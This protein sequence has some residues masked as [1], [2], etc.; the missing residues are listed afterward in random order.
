MW[1]DLTVAVCLLGFVGAIALMLAELPTLVAQTR[2]ALRR[3]R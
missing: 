3:H 2:R 1:E